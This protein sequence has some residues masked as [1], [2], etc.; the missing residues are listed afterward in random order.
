[1][2]RIL[3]LLGIAMA[4][5]CHPGVA[6]GASTAPAGGA[7]PA[8]SGTVHVDG[9]VR[10]ITGDTLD[11]R[12]PPGRAVVAVIG[13]RAPRGNTPCGREATAFLQALVVDGARFEEE[14]GLVLD[15]RS[16][17]LYHV[18]TPDGRSVAAEL[19]TA[20]LAWADGQGNGRESLA[21][22]QTAAQQARRGCLWPAGRAP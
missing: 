11:A 10:A 15:G 21:E 6:V 19:V 14:P 12:L 7:P 20:G 22:L 3:S 1:L 9:Y 18:I 13:I 16:R 2:G 17:R 8:G 4:A 5:V